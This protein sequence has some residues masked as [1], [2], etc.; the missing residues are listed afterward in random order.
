MPR[1][2][3]FVGD[4]HLGRSPHRM[5]GCGVELSELSPQA[6]WIRVVD[7]ALALEV[8]AVVLAGD[9]VDG[10]RDRFEALNPLF[11]GIERL[12]RAGIKTVMVVGNHDHYA[13]PV[14]VE[15]IQRSPW[16]QDTS[17]HL[18]GRGSVWERLDLDG[19]TLYGWSFSQRHHTESPLAHPSWSGLFEQ[20]PAGAVAIGVVHGDLDV[21]TSQYAPLSRA[22][23]ERSPADAWFLGHI[24]KP[25]DLSGDRPLGYLG[26]LAGL[27]RAEV[28][29]RGPWLVRIEAGRVRAE[30]LCLGPLHWVTLTVDV[31]TLSLAGS[32]EGPLD[33]LDSAVEDALAACAQSD[34]WLRQGEVVAVGCSLCFVGRND[35]RAA[36]ARYLR[37]R[38]NQRF[39][40]EGLIWALVSQRNLTKPAF[41]LEK[42]AGE[43][44]PL[45]RLAR[46]IR[47]LEASGA[48]ALSEAVVGADQAFDPRPWRV[49]RDSEYEAGLESVAIEVAYELLDELMAQ[50]EQLEGVDAP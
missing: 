8:Q 28:G 18:L 29:R 46:Q 32:G 14:L 35:H 24:H 36:V 34:A 33:A 12:S 2:I 11:V 1:P 45:G 21:V 41:D 13:L 48:S 47:A 39:E 42:M 5:R 3:L 26:S 37:E 38:P 22:E 10:E 23:L 31:S 6:A 16:A 50:R 27:D 44:T 7:R 9:V 20:T 30:Q 49:A 40:R 25:N 43:K 19:V 17:L 4:I 15:R